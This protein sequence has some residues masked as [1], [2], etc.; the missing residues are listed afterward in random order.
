MTRAGLED[1]FCGLEFLD[2]GLGDGR[3]AWRKGI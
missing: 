1:E 2:E 3:G